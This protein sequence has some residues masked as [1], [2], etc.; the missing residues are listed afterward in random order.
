MPT[1]MKDLLP[2]LLM[3]ALTLSWLLYS[4]QTPPAAPPAAFASTTVP[5]DDGAVF[6]LDDLT[7]QREASG[8]PY[9]PFLTLPTLRA[10]L[11]ALPAGGT[12]RQQPHDKDELYYVAE[13]RAAITIGKT[14]YALRPGAVIFVAAGATHRFHD[15][16][17]DLQ[18]LVF[19]SEADPASPED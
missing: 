10:G 7:T 14:E 8:R 1:P 11:Y 15:I 3:A 13:G 5:D 17:E 18:L 9:L 4:Q 16:E 19:F 6:Y 2:W 12:D